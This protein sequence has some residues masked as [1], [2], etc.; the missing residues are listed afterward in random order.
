M[1]N[2]YALAN[3]WGENNHKVRGERLPVT[4]PKLKARRPA[5]P[6][7]SQEKPA[8]NASRKSLPQVNMP[9]SERP[10]AETSES[11]RAR[12]TAFKRRRQVTR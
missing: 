8:P 4:G 3:L 12:E 10:V 5:K 2:V 1:S 6:V 7:P 11:L 9:P